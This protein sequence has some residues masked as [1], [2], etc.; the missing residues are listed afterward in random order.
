MHFRKMT[1]VAGREGLLLDA[2]RAVGRFVPVGGESLDA[3]HP[4]GEAEEK[5]H[6]EG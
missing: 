6:F 4:R 1:W 3:G 2:R 5:T